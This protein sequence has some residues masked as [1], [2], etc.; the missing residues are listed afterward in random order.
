MAQSEENFIHGSIIGLAC[1][2]GKT[3]C[4]LLAVLKIN[5]RQRQLATEH[6]ETPQKYKA[7][8]VCCP[9]PSVE[10]WQA[11]IEKFFPQ[12]FTVHQFFGTETS[13]TNLARRKTLVIPPNI[14]EFNRI[15]QQLDANDPQV[16]T[17]T[18]SLLNTF[19]KALPE[20]VQ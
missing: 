10:V 18:R 6:P 8:M 16:S 17:Q 3:L 5:E 15:C 11:D 4:S 12:T 7:T 1:G 2:L 13:V 14:T 9:G 19:S 20:H